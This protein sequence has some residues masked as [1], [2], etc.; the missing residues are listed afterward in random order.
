M[1]ARTSKTKE[2]EDR[3]EF[4]LNFFINA[5]A[6]ARRK[7][8]TDMI[9]YGRDRYVMSGRWIFME[10]RKTS[11]RL[12]ERDVPFQILYDF[13]MF[14]AQAL[15]PRAR[16]HV[17]AEIFLDSPFNSYFEK[18]AAPYRFQLSEI[19]LRTITENRK[20]A[21]SDLMPLL[22]EID[23]TDGP[24]M[25]EYFKRKISLIEPLKSVPEKILAAAYG[26]EGRVAQLKKNISPDPETNRKKAI[27]SLDNFINA[28]NIRNGEYFVRRTK[29]D[30]KLSS[31]APS[32]E[33]YLK[34]KKIAAAKT[35]TEP[36]T[37]TENS[38]DSSSPDK[39]SADYASTD[40]PYEE[41]YQE[42]YRETHPGAQFSPETETP[43]QQSESANAAPD[44]DTEQSAPVWAASEADLEPGP[45]QKTSPPF[46]TSDT[47]VSPGAF[48]D[49]EVQIDSFRAELLTIQER[50]EPIRQRI[51]SDRDISSRLDSLEATGDIQEAVR[52]LAEFPEDLF[53]AHRNIALRKIGE[54]DGMLGKIMGHLSRVSRHLKSHDMRVYVD[55]L[56]QVLREGRIFETHPHIEER[57]I[58]YRNS[59][60]DPPP[61]LLKEIHG[62][63][64][65][66]ESQHRADHRACV[67]AQADYLESCLA[68]EKFKIVWPTSFTILHNLL[69][70]ELESMSEGERSANPAWK[71]R[72]DQ[73]AEETAHHRDTILAQIKTELKGETAVSILSSLA[74]PAGPAPAAGMPH[75]SA[76][77]DVEKISAEILDKD[78]RE[79]AAD[80]SGMFERKFSENPEQA[81]AWA[82]T[83]MNSPQTD[84]LEKET[85]L[86]LCRKHSSRSREAAGF[87][88]FHN[89]VDNAPENLK[90]RIISIFAGIQPNS[91]LLEKRK[92]LEEQR[93]CFT[94]KS[95]FLSYAKETDPESRKRLAEQIAADE[96]LPAS[97][98]ASISH[99]DK[100]NFDEVIKAITTSIHPVKT[101]LEM[102]R[103][104]AYL[105]DKKGMM[106]PARREKLDRIYRRYEG[107]LK[108]NLAVF[109]RN[110]PKN[111][112]FFSHGESVASSL[113]AGT[114]PSEIF[115]REIAHS[116]DYIAASRATAALEAIGQNDPDNPESRAILA[117]VPGEFAAQVQ[118]TLKKKS[119][120]QT[121]ALKQIRSISAKG[122]LSEASLEYLQN[123]KNRTVAMRWYDSL[124][125]EGRSALLEKSVDLQ[126]RQQVESLFSALGEEVRLTDA[127]KD[128]KSLAAEDWDALRQTYSRPHQLEK[129]K[130][131]QTVIS[132]AQKQP[133]MTA[134]SAE[135]TAPPEKDSPSQEKEIKPVM[136]FDDLINQAVSSAIPS[137]HD[138]EPPEPDEIFKDR[139]ERRREPDLEITERAAPGQRSP[140]KGTRDA[141]AAGRVPIPDR[142]PAKT[143]PA[144][145]KKPPPA[146]KAGGSIIESVSQSLGGLL[147]RM[148]SPSKK[149]EQD[150]AKTTKTEA[151]QKGKGKAGKKSLLPVTVSKTIS[152]AVKAKLNAGGGSKYFFTEKEK[153]AMMD[154][155]AGKLKSSQKALSPEVLEQEVANLFRDFSYLIPMNENEPDIK[156]RKYFSAAMLKSKKQ[157]LIKEYY[158]LFDRENERLKKQEYS[159]IISFLKSH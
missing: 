46:E 6:P 34:E 64:Q 50:L 45:I 156:K 9:K 129:I 125:G 1:A 142:T 24:A 88:F 56:I 89:S 132:A 65:D 124:E 47:D 81:L 38:V 4:T 3:E 95:L 35:V 84:S 127:L 40:A 104:F 75:F 98:R 18:R 144:A 19:E 54:M 7:F 52:I 69:R 80:I 101:R 83:F 100:S 145:K 103:A 94:G 71:Q 8:I 62:R 122:G 59:F 159:D 22:A 39:F 15:H 119:A 55:Y 61:E 92:A 147:G 116:Q 153:E 33:Q 128:T 108:E 20:I 151:D 2:T 130:A 154:Q 141:A 155:A 41:E 87:Y 97:L 146:E 70:E 126:K 53:E 102:L 135:P 48:L 42:E 11:L 121:E 133:A 140:A 114:S 136:N 78:P 118:A 150:A 85:I 66:L 26:I 74:L 37:E 63:L 25:V 149:K 143:A 105:A 44:T 58:N 137:M 106:T 120:A 67:I 14:L 51:F 107:F 13:E 96:R 28:H 117:A 157:E 31:L 57:L 23:R 29:I 110:K 79:I 36:D 131:V 30:A 27:E 134:A 91:A 90:D 139:P 93:A 148:S 49:E 109:T 112:F 111:H 10:A 17:G 12:Q 68:D 115:S 73:F 138:E 86:A 76:A 72:I 32:L 5:D 82:A 152:D 21:V 16:T 99:K 123:P 77:G 43:L 158:D 113:A 60:I